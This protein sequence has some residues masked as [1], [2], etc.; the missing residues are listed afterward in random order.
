MTTA[1]T[2]RVRAGA[3]GSTV[4]GHL[5]GWDHVEWWVG[6]ARAMTSWL[7][8]GF[9][10]EVDAYAGPETGVPDRASYLL[11]QGDVRFVVTAGLTPAS[12]VSRHVLDHGDGVRALAWSV[13]DPAAVAAL[14]E[15][16][17]AKVAAEPFTEVG[18]QGRFTT[19]SVEGYGTVV[20]SFVDR[21][22]W[23]GTWGPGFSDEGLPGHWALAPVGV[24]NIDH[25][26]GN[27]GEGHL[28]RWVAWSRE[29]LGFEEMVH[30]SA[31]QISTRYSALRSTVMY[32][33]HPASQGGIV[34]PVNEPAPG[35][36]KS[37][38][39]EY[40]EAFGG[41]GVQHIALATP[42]IVSAVANMRSRSVRFLHMP[43]SYYQ[44]A[45]QRC[46]G[47]DLPWGDL[48]R[49]GIEVDQDEGGY[50]LQIFSETLA[51]RPTFFMEVIQREGASGFGEGN[52]KALFE[53]IE[54]EQ[55]RRHNL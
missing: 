41:P 9:G 52:F 40:L 26:V 29:V 53:A 2:A 24:R 43:G 20:F 33:G 49:L 28:D 10:F 25:V 19:A 54:R 15:R 32:N 11:R 16:R 12:E 4:A 47:L 8:G 18:G 7:C 3:G 38:V 5:L 35:L 50:L 22:G 45:R 21:S 51:D 14:A 42:D 34:L 44:D 48:E 30:F 46:A 17:G 36:R 37:Q 31:E 39:T 6:N 27:V 13:R 55:A 23:R 1:T